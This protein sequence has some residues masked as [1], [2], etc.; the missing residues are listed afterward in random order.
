MKTPN[1]PFSFSLI[2][3]KTVFRFFRLLA[4]D[5][6]TIGMISACIKERNKLAHASGENMQDL[7]KKIE[8]YI[9]NMEKIVDKSKDFLIEVYD[10]FVSDNQSLLVDD[11][12]IQS[13]DIESSFLMPYCISIY[14]LEQII[15]IIPKNKIITALK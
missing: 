3:E 14:E 2:N 1:S 8:C 4:F 7:E 9:S 6:G 10:K 11:Y 15:A 12:E 13:Y 5:D